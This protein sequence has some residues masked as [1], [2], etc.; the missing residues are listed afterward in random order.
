[1]AS[2]PSDLDS[3][4]SQFNEPPPTLTTIY[5]TIF[6]YLLY[7]IN[8]AGQ[9]VTSMKARLASKPNDPPNS[10]KSYPCRPKLPIRVFMPKSYHGSSGQNLPTLFTVHGGGFVM[11]NPQ[12]DDAWNRYFSDTYSV[13][14]IAL[15]YPKA[16]SARFPT[17]IYDL[18][19]LILAALS[20][21]SLPIDKDRV[22][23]AGFSAGGNLALSVSTLPSMCGSGDGIRRIKAIIS[24]Y[25]PVDMS[26]DRN[27]KTQT[28]RYKPSLGGFRARPTD[29][30]LRLSPIFDW[31][32]IPH[33]QDLQDPLLSP[34]YASKDAL[35]PYVFMIACELDM[36]VGDSH[37]MICGLAGRPVG[38]VRVGKD[39]P[40]PVGELILDDENYCFEDSREN[41]S[42]K[43][44]LVP[45]QV[46]SFDH[47]KQMESVHRDKVHA[48]D[49]EPKAK[50][51]Q[52]LIAEWLFPGPFK[53]AA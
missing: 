6:T 42:Y 13:L 46:H 26:I 52:K 7:Y 21:S 37:R 49:A 9:R 31:A 11:G 24:L 40:A 19:Q 51:S 45:D 25:A 2:S 30:L 16:P 1:M 4:R 12:N 35:P 15:D 14:V 34:I 39:E 43:W 41:G 18:E 38:E 23:I 22:A 27:Y 8:R 50:H 33:G 3:A 20:D 36:L 44:L 17:A 29:W 48:L 47:H 28:R 5:Y 10:T 53:Q 32:Y